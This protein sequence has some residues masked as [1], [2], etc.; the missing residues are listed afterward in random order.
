MSP[1]SLTIAMDESGYTGS[2][3]LDSTQP[4]FIMSSVNISLQDAQK[5]LHKSPKK[6]QKFAELKESEEGRKIILD[7]IKYL[8]KQNSARY[9]VVNKKFVLLTLMVELLIEP[10]LNR[11]GSTDY[12]L[13]VANKIY[14]EMLSTFGNERLE[15]LL[16]NFQSMIKS[17][18]KFYSDVRNIENSLLPDSIS[19][20]GLLQNNL[21][22]FIRLIL[23]SQSYIQ[24]TIEDSAQVYDL[25]KTIV[26]GHIDYWKELNQSLEIL[27]DENKP[28]RELVIE[29]GL[30]DQNFKNVT[31]VPTSSSNEPRIQ[32]ADILSGAA[33]QLWTRS[34]FDNNPLEIFDKQLKEANLESLHLDHI[35]PRIDDIEPKNTKLQSK[36]NHKHS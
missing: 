19:V 28:I 1:Q 27:Y 6:K 22:D 21:W 14:Y 12:R 10:S 31:I 33:N 35:F 36:Q 2:N 16:G 5:L 9:I 11:K 32:I 3:F 26:R 4:L 17:T 8:V 7:V 23:K 18:K 24:E 29:L 13:S 34:I 15:K 30:F 25:C 20:N